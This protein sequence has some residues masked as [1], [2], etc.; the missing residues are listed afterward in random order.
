M[1]SMT[2]RKEKFTMVS[3]SN[4]QDDGAKFRGT[5]QFLEGNRIDFKGFDEFD[6]QREA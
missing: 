6:E 2:S 4:P 1:N 5:D 3:S